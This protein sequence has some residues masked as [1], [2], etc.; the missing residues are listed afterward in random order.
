MFLNCTGNSDFVLSVTSSENESSKRSHFNTKRS[1]YHERIKNGR[2]RL[3]LNKSRQHPRIHIGSS[4]SFHSR[5]RVVL[6]APGNYY[7][8][9]Y[10]K[11]ET[12]VFHQGVVAVSN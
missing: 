9:D 10:N 6:H 12:P 4:S 1:V 11:S 2:A 5:E 8:T 3:V 7:R